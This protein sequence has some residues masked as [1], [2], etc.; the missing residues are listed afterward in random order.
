MTPIPLD[1]C[2]IEEHE[3]PGD[4]AQIM[5]FP[6]LAEPRLF[7]RPIAPRATGYEGWGGM[8]NQALANALD[9]VGEVVV[10]V[11]LNVAFFNL[12]RA[13]D[14]TGC[15]RLRPSFPLRCANAF[16]YG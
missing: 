7:M 11:L 15:L 4:L 13:S 1:Q 6:E 2:V 8:V 16:L 5:G 3:S 12:L 9:K 10:F 14:G